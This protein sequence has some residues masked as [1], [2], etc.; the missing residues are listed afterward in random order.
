VPR[1]LKTAEMPQ[2]PREVKS[3]VADGVYSL[4]ELDTG[5]A[6]YVLY[7][8]QREAHYLLSDDG[9]IVRYGPGGCRNGARIVQAVSFADAGE[10]VRLNFRTELNPR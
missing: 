6:K 5:D 8:Q 2:L 4:Y 10:G 9:K 1:F 7:T 3:L